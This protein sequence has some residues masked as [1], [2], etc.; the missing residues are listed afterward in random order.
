[1][2]ATDGIAIVP[3]DVTDALAGLALSTS[4]VALFNFFLAV[5]NLIPGYPMDGA[6]IVH[7]L[8]WA[9]SG[10]DDVGTTVASRVGR[11]VGFGIMALGAV[12]VAV[13]DLWPGLALMI[14]FYNNRESIDVEDVNLLKW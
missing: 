1:M 10:R 3:L 14:A 11:M 9:R 5:V 8:A 2:A 7:S 6:R 12:V 4:T 13:V